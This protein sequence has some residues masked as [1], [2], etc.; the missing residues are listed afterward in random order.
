MIEDELYESSNIHGNKV[1]ID[2]REHGSKENLSP[3]E[4]LLASVAACGAVD[5]V[6]MLKKR[7]KKIVDFQIETE[8]TR[9][10]EPPRWVKSLHCNYIIVSPD[11]TEEELEKVARLALEKYCSVASSLKSEI[12]FS[13]EVRR[14]K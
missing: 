5:I 14:E 13:V 3:V 6:I 12:S 10:P 4:N 2:M 11:V 9:N 1:R 7:K 8:A